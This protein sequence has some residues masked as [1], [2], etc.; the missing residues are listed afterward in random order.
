MERSGKR[1]YLM[2]IKPDLYLETERL[3]LRPFEKEI[4]LIGIHNMIIGCHLNTNMM[5]VAL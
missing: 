3:I 2:K 1:G 4:I 5:R